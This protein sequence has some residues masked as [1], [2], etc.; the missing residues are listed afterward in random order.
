MYQISFGQDNFLPGFTIQNSGDTLY[1]FIDYRNW[2]I[3]PKSI[4]FKE[5]NE[6]N[7]I[8]YS[9]LEIKGFGVYNEIYESAIVVIDTSSVTTHNLGYDFEIRPR[10]DTIFLQVMF[11]GDKILYNYKNIYKEQFYIKSESG[12]E[13]LVYK[14]YIKKIVHKAMEDYSAS[15][16]KFIME[17]KGYLL[18]LS[19]YLG[20]CSTIIPEINKT[21][22]NKKDMERL[23]NYY[24]N[25]I[26]KEPLFT[27]VVEKPKIE[28]GI[29]GGLSSNT[30]NFTGDSNYHSHLIDGEFNSSQNLTI[31]LFL[32]LV[33]PR[34]QK[35]WSLNYDMVYSSFNV[36]GYHEYIESENKY[37][38]TDTKLEYSFIK[39]SLSICYK[40][41]IGK[42][43]LFMNAGGF[44]SIYISQTNYSK[45]L[46]MLY[47]YERI[48]EKKAIKH[49]RPYEVGAFV[50]L[51]AE[52]KYFHL[53]LRYERGNGMSRLLN[54]KTTTDKLYLLLGYKF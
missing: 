25:C 5:S 7:L 10:V 12:F 2:S 53:D 31:G 9:P 1:G 39:P 19:K 37:T 3:N 27:R 42:I 48:T 18:Q 46:E 17:N 50:N 28:F 13:L 49:T 43:D 35:R 38:I 41:Y 54:L 36:K 21:K 8:N 6:S 33:L 24:Y 20:E 32:N 45:V 11:T 16:K 26:G 23:F 22:Y 52:Y 14:K 51:G 44:S 4:R 15:E 34:N 47:T 30:I 40:Y 29:T